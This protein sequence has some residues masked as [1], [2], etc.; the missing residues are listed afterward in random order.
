MNT[1]LDPMELLLLED[2]NGIGKR[3]D[4]IIVGDG[5]ALNCLLPQRKALVATP[6]VRKRYA[7]QIKRRAEESEHDRKMHQ[8]AADAVL[9]KV[10]HFTRKVAKT[11]TLYAAITAKDISEALAAEHSVNIAAGDIVIAE[12]IKSIGNVTVQIQIGEQTYPLQISVA[13]EQT[14]PKKA[15]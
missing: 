6:T 7:E 8:Q 10:V 2:I 12:P 5:F 9:G 14:Q 15:A 3:N 4:I 11:D 1:L 13:R